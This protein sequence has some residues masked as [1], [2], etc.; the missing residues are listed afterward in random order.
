MDCNYTIITCCYNA[1]KYVRQYF[2]C[3]NNL[4]YDS[5]E[6]IVVDDNSTDDTYALL[7]E[8][9]LT[10]DKDI[11]ILRQ[12]RNL[13]PGIAR[14]KALAHASGKYIVFWDIDD[15]IE[16]IMFDKTDRFIGYDIVYFNYFKVYAGKKYKVHS[17]NAEEGEILD[18]DRLMKMTPGCVWG[19]VFRKDL[20]DRYRIQFPDLYKSED[21]VFMI[22]YLSHCTSVF[23]SCDYAYSYYINKTSIMHVNM[24]SQVNYA[25]KAFNIIEQLKISREVL[26]V[27]YCREIIY[28]LS[29]VYLICGYD[30]K[31]ILNFWNEH[32]MSTEWTNE[33]DCFTIFQKLF[34]RFVFHKS[35]YGAKILSFIKEFL[36]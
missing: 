36:G 20:I 29:L 1:S 10:S 32:T 34:L 23:Y 26:D 12:K 14:N 2:D 4:Y 30:K 27:L 28:D 7:S 31:F 8:F 6:V 19:K 18:I 9:S 3:L 21:L 24:E 17:L 22:T 11:I 15:S 35:Y 13:G 5:L 33:F 16:S 25:T